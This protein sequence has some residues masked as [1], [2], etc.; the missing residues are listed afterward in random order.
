[1]QSI[2]KPCGCSH[3]LSS[4]PP[5]T[6][7]ASSHSLSPSCVLSDWSQWAKWDPCFLSWQPTCCFCLLPSAQNSPPGLPHCPIHASLFLI[8]IPITVS[9][10]CFPVSIFYSSPWRLL[11]VPTSVFCSDCSLP[12]ISQQAPRHSSV[13]SFLLSEA[14]LDISSS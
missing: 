8:W 10:P 3:S 13:P 9:W 5:L 12:P 14:G 7:P 6:L 1:M 2:G 11:G 4:V